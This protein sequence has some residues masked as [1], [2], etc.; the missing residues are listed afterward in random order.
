MTLGNRSSAR[1]Q[2]GDLSLVARPAGDGKLGETRVRHGGTEMV[3]S[4]RILKPPQGSAKGYARK[5]AQFLA[6]H[7]ARRRSRGQ[8]ISIT[9]K[10]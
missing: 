5:L 4:R 3:A 2:A 8:Y 10:M 9:V 7:P 1:S 6:L